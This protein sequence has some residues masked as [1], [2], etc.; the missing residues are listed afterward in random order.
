MPY[1]I[2]QMQTP[3]GGCPIQGAPE[4]RQEIAWGG[5]DRR[6]AKPQGV[7]ADGLEALKG[8]RKKGRGRKG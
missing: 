6:E 8:R 5:A 7:E 3:D 2:C 1:A 4:G